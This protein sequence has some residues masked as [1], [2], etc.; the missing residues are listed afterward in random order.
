MKINVYLTLLLIFL[1]S[2]R[3]LAGNCD[4]TGQILY[5]NMDETQG[6]AIEAIDGGGHM[7]GGYVSS[8][9]DMSYFVSRL[10]SNYQVM[11]SNKYSASNNESDVSFDLLVTSDDHIVFCG[12]TNEPSQD[13]FL[14]K[15][16][17]TG[18][19]VWDL[20]L[21]LPATRSETGVDVSETSNG[22][23]L[24][25]G[26]TN[27][28]AGTVLR[29]SDAYL[30]RI[31]SAGS[32]VWQGNYGRPRSDGN[33]NDHFKRTYELSSGEILA[34]NNKNQGGSS[35]SRRIGLTKLDSAGNI[36]FYTR[37]YSCSSG[38]SSFGYGRI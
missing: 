20:V 2:M 21:K 8:P 17:A 33:W 5:N 15:L 16:D 6:L 35:S 11:W 37:V 9:G 4:Y 18:N 22:D 30:A 25:S 19:L 34:L 3:G 28:A 10:N 13:I 27:L 31:S 26:T 1:W 23:L 14:V 29:A 38:R 36:V 7:V 24:V 12:S 32:I